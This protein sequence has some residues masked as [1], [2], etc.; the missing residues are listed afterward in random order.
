MKE[1]IERLTK[2][3]FQFVSSP[4]DEYWRG[5]EVNLYIHADGTCAWD[6]PI[7]T[8]R[9]MNEFFACLDRLRSIRF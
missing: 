6:R 3:G 7:G 8:A 4:V 1:L 2:Y 5:P 9:T